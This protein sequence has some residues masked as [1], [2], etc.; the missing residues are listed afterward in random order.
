MEIAIIGTGKLA[1][2]LAFAIDKLGDDIRLKT[3]CGRSQTKVQIITER[4]SCLYTKDISSVEEH[5]LIIIAVKDDAIHSVSNHL[6]NDLKAL[7]VHTSGIKDL[8]TIDSHKNHG[9][10]YPLYSFF[11]KEET[12]LKDVPFLIESNSEKSTNKLKR[13]ANLLSGTV[14]EIDAEHKQ[15]LHLAAVFANNFSNFMMTNAMDLLNQKS[16]NKNILLPIIKQSCANWSIGKSK[17]NQSGPAMRNDKFTIDTHLE[18]LESK[19][20]KELY[21]IISK[22]ITNYYS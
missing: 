21:E 14:Y 17:N 20:Q 7:V 5:D 15:Q 6:P 18:K 1:H 13:I 12:S 3:I 2:Q 16:I 22:A 10:L 8:D 11:N 19:E 4:T 9:I